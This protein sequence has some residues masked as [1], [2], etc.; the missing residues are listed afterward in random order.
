MTITKLTAY[1]QD[2]EP[3]RLVR[4]AKVKA[5]L[6]A[7]VLSELLVLHDSKGC[8]SVNWRRLPRERHIQAVIAAWDAQGEWQSEHY[9]DGRLFHET[10]FE[11]RRA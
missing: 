11:E 4:L 8:L 10:V 3:W 1:R 2:E 9:V 6:P 5:S 7:E